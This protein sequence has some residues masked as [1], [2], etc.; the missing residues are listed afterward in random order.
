MRD[1]D[2]EVREFV[3]HNVAKRIQSF[4][5]FSVK[6]SGQC[7]DLQLD[8]LSINLLNEIDASFDEHEKQQREQNK[9]PEF[10]TMAG[11]TSKD[12][13]GVYQSLRL[14]SKENAFI[15]KDK[16][17]QFGRATEVTEYNE[18]PI[19][20]RVNPGKL[21]GQFVVPDKK[22]RRY[23]VYKNHLEGWVLL[24]HDNLILLLDDEDE[25]KKV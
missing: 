14:S 10:V 7:P 11:N 2:K 9:D 15:R 23:A 16:L 5:S 6:L 24:T 19:W 25:W 13:L 3:P 17:D 12:V 22:D 21:R 18:Q 20:Q 1:T 8:D 4:I